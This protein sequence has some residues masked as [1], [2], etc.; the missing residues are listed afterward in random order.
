MINNHTKG[1]IK[2]LESDGGNLEEV[3]RLIAAGADLYYQNTS[4]P[5]NLA[6][7]GGHTTTVEA[8]IDAG[9][10]VNM[11]EVDHSMDIWRAYGT[12]DPKAHKRGKENLYQ[13]GESP[14]MS[15]AKNG[16]TDTVQALI[17]AG[18]DI[19]YCNITPL[20]G[21]GPTALTFAIIGEHIETVKFLIKAGAKFHNSFPLAC[22]TGNLAMVKKLLEAGCENWITDGLLAAS[23]SGHSEVVELLIRTGAD[24][25]GGHQFSAL[26][27]ASSGGHIKVVELLL[28]SGA[29][30]NTQT[31]GRYTALG[32]A[33]KYGHKDIV[34]LLK[35]A[36]AKLT[37]AQRLLGP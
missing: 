15:A 35:R 33:K 36:G 32:L 3:K 18:A 25:N 1:L 30:V 27:K 17:K 28:K 8:L 22:S 2:T 19:N 34:R 6:A 4:T 9:A 13:R 37:F 5:L 16:H 21:G 7:S 23:K 29:N 14:L 31:E 24:V 10:D 26:M 12:I 20:F 11:T